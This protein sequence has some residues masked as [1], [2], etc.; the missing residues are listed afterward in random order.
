M[1]PSDLKDSPILFLLSARNIDP[2]C[3]FTFFSLAEQ[4]PLESMP[5]AFDDSFLNFFAIGQYGLSA[6]RIDRR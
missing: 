2:V 3:V 5:F 1:S 4:I 6:F